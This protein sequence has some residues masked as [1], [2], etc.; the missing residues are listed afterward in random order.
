MG[1]KTTSVFLLISIFAIGF[2][3]IKSIIK[4]EKKITIIEFG[5]DTFEQK[6]AKIFQVINNNYQEIDSIKKWTTIKNVTLNDSIKASYFFLFEELKKIEVQEKNKREK[7]MRR[8]YIM[9]TQLSY[10]VEQI[11]EINI[12]TGIANPEY[13]EEQSFF[14]KE[15]LQKQSN[16]QDCGSPMSARYLKGEEDRLQTEFHNL[17]M[18]LKK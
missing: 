8:F 18:H 14:L 7:I 2:I 16:N 5:G 15:N 11:Q 10:V 1:R 4:K 12:K 3:T 9:N 6:I 17:K 13:L